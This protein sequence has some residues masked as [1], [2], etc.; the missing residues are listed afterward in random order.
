MH[1]CP[2]VMFF[3]H[4]TNPRAQNIFR[5]AM[6]SSL[7]LFHVVPAAMKRQYEILAGKSELSSPHSSRVR[8]SHGS[9]HSGDRTSLVGGRTFRSV[10]HLWAILL[11]PPWKNKTKPKKKWTCLPLFVVNRGP[12]QGALRSQ[13][14]DMPHRRNHWSRVPHPPQPPPCSAE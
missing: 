14:G 4:C 7:I 1:F 10:T 8:F 3:P 13:D 11:E 5:Q 9:L 6:A 12:W 2:Y